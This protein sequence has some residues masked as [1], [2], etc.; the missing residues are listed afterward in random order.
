MPDRASDKQVAVP[1]PLPALIT[2]ASSGIGADLARIFA[3]HGHPLA[4]V[5][6]T[7]SR[8]DALADEIHAAHAAPGTPRPV[9]I[10]L[11][12]SVPDSPAALAR[13]LE[14]QGF[15]PGILVNNAGYGMLGTVSSQI[16]EKAPALLA[17]MDLNMRA[18]TALTLHFLPQITAQR[19][20]ILNVAS[21]AAFFPGPGMAVYYA[22]KAFVLSFSEALAHELAASGVRV[23]SLCP[24]PTAT[25]FFDRAGAAGSG[26]S[27]MAMMPSMPV[28]EAGYRGLMAGKR[29][30]VPG[31]TN[32]V[33]TTFAPMIP[34]A[35]QL[36]I[37]ARLQMSR[38][39][40]S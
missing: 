5:A 8:L 39:A 37:I 31:L 26:V 20:A 4:L 9:V 2:G 40:K 23:S 11:D 19:G 27:Q 10:P 14:Q 29:V 25:E 33:L 1:A 17:M 7:T 35:I 22:S 28:A 12:L 38:T 13:A 34:K 21:T 24:G 36:R 15:T 30:I 16:P 32:K 6:R 18:L 3:R